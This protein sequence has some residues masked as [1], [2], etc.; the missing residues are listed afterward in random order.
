MPMEIIIGTGLGLVCGF[1][2]RGSV[3]LDGPYGIDVYGIWEESAGRLIGADL[4]A[5]QPDAVGHGEQRPH[6]L[7]AHCLVLADLTAACSTPGAK[8]EEAP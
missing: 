6:S 1:G 2:L 8:D 4:R 3:E 7:P 5:P